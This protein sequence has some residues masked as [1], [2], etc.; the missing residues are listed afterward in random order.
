MPLAE[1]NRLIYRINVHIHDLNYQQ[2]IGQSCLD[3]DLGTI[4]SIVLVSFGECMSSYLVNDKISKQKETDF[5]YTN[6]CI[7]WGKIT[8]YLNFDKC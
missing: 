3:Y 6:K 4:G 1:K 2:F 7:V 5:I 8:Q